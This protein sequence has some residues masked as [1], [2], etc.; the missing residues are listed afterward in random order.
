MDR[1]ITE[2]LKEIRK[3]TFNI[4]PPRELWET[5][6]V[7]DEGEVEDMAYAEEYIYGE[8]E[9]V[10]SVTGIDAESLPPPQKLTKKQKELLATELEN[11]LQYFHFHLDFPEGYPAYLRYPFIKNFWKEKHVALS[12]GES[13]IEL[14][15]YDEG[16]CPFP[17]YCT[18]CAEFKAEEETG[19]PAGDWDFDVDELLLTPEELKNRLKNSGTIREQPDVDFPFGFE[20]EE[21]EYIENIN[22]LYNDEG[23]KIDPNAIPL[24]GLCVI[25]KNYDSIDR[26]E[27]LLCLM[28]RN[29]WTGNPGFECGAFEKK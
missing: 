27:N 10:S 5:A 17:G 8:K 6:D 18:T 14:C 3:A 29:A 2:L 11:L 24:P 23:A 7:D 12:F 26:D 16:N 21:E 15:D 13:H 20:N 9:P 28:N 22:G 19:Y 1:Y 25:C 4:R